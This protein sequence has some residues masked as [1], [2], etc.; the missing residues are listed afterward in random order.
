MSMPATLS[1][2]PT[3]D[4]PGE[5]RGQPGGWFQILLPQHIL[6][7]LKNSQIRVVPT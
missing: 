2:C 7:L 3:P 4:D 1:G 5:A 6:D